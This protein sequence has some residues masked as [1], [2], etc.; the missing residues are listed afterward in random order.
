M[1]SKVR[2]DNN[3]EALS[4][5]LSSP[6]FSVASYL[7]AALDQ[8]QQSDNSHN[9]D[10]LSQR[11]AELAL[12]LQLQ[13]QSC[14][15]DIGK[16]GAELQAILPRC[17]A[18]ISRIA[19]G[20]QGLQSDAQNLDAIQQQVIRD[21]GETSSSLETL[22][23]LHALQ[24]NLKRTQEILLAAATWDTTLSSISNLLAQQHLVEAVAALE[25]L[26]KDEQALRGMPGGDE[27]QQVVA[28]IRQQV[29][30]L[31][32]PQ[33]Q[34][35]LANMASRLAPL[36]QCV[37]L[38]RQLDS[39]ETLQKEYL[40]NRPSSVHKAWF[41][42]KPT[43]TPNSAET[44]QQLSDNFVS[45]LPGWLDAVLQ[46]VSDERRQSLSV[47]GAS[48]V[49]TMTLGVFTECFRPILSSF[50]SRLEQQVCSTKTVL[51]G[52][53]QNV[54]TC[55]ESVL[56]FLSVA[57]ETMIGGWLDMVESNVLSA[58]D[59]DAVALYQQ[60]KDAFLQVVSPFRPYQEQLVALEAKHSKQLTNQLAQK[61]KQVA[62]DPSLSLDNLSMDDLQTLALDVFDISKNALAR[63][64]LMS[65]GYNAGQ[66]LTTI[67]KLLA[68]HANEVSLALHK[69]SSHVVSQ[70]SNQLDDSHVVAALQV[71][72]LAGQVV[73]EL[74]TLQNTT[75]ERM[76]VV[77]DRMVQHNSR[78]DQ[79]T[80]AMTRRSSAKGPAF[81]L[82]EALSAVEI[83]SFV[84]QSVCAKD[85]TDGASL[86]A[87]QRLATSDQSALYPEMAE[88]VQRLAHSGHSFVFDVCYAVPQNYLQ[89]VPSMSAWKEA[90]DA[91][92]LA[93][94]GTLPQ[95]YITHVGEHMLALVQALEPFASEKDAL[96][97]A[98]TV[99]DGVRDVALPAWR[100]LVKA[101]GSSN[102]DS[103]ARLL[104]EGKDIVPLVV[105]SA[106]LEDDVDDGEDELDAAAKSSAAFCNSWLDVVGLAVTGRLLELIMRIPALTPKGCEH[107]HADLSY[108]VN[109]FSAL[110]VTGHPHPLLGH[111]AESAILDRDALS[112]RIASRDK[113]SHL[114]E[115]IGAMEERLLAIRG[116]AAQYNY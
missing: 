33:L 44:A 94:Y 19:V 54:S 116:A 73:Q 80:Q 82:P 69:I 67:D 71:L 27:R 115:A 24:A 72:P 76:S 2:S 38:Y 57:Y 13:T 47:F 25:Q 98:Q 110:G 63:F 10:A 9:K 111:I 46:L 41:E 90:S 28:K 48:M 39:M 58:N 45:W 59:L 106:V 50:A 16:L 65:G 64:E 35:A 81:A 96:T 86:T 26:V 32:Q 42:Y 60:V 20:L 61:V 101:S 100:D 17:G 30:V 1:S 99:M 79:I 68:S 5:I 97:L 36:Q 11:M 12:Q 6:D 107:L 75:Q 4:A 109:V 66:A 70:L 95:Q 74:A 7:N 23:T 83:D 62:N 29:T 88:A 14:H 108:L 15:E 40:Q 105:S 37:V 31:L 52:S 53:L 92:N 51:R 78:Q 55:Y 43:V 102:V 8:T 104:M 56:Q 3:D 114:D 84:T 93:S 113:S 91:D 112:D 49:P 89:S 21:G 22:S 85:D 34:H 103:I 87:L 77:R 18:D